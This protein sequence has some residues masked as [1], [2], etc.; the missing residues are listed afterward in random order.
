MEESSN[1]STLSTIAFTIVAIIIGYFI[2]VGLTNEISKNKKQ[3]DVSNVDTVVIQKEETKTCE[4]SKTEADILAYKL[5]DKFKM[6]QMDVDSE[7]AK[8]ISL[9]SLEQRPDCSWVAI[10]KITSWYD[11][12]DSEQI[13][14]RFICDGKEI[15]V[16]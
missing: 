9:Y 14:K 13:T 15:Y 11:R 3:T 6:S 4:C 8:D 5:I 10:F 16:Q 2:Y 1:H 7:Y 12:S